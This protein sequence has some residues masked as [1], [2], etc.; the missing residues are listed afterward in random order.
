MS[1]VDHRMPVIH[2]HEALVQQAVIFVCLVEQTQIEILQLLVTLAATIHLL[3]VVQPAVILVLL[4]AWTQIVIPQQ[5]AQLVFLEG[6]GSIF[7]QTS[8]S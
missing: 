6:I 7:R 2:A 1:Q 3:A 4:V 5:H 8:M